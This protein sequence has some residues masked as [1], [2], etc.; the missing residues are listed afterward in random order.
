MSR[1][2]E[3]R[4]QTRH[5]FG[6]RSWLRSR[7]LPRVFSFD[8]KAQRQTQCVSQRLHVPSSFLHYHLS[9]SEE[10]MSTKCGHLFK[11]FLCQL[12]PQL[13]CE[14]VNDRLYIGVHMRVFMS[15]ETLY[16][17]KNN[18]IVNLALFQAILSVRVCGCGCGCVR[19]HC[20][21]R[22]S[23]TRLSPG[24]RQKGFECQVMNLF[25]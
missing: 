3:F 15:L 5:A 17:F 2:D 7:A 4:F 9:T 22:V 11:E 6:G 8:D 16:C 21:H 24:H 20:T 1:H 23:L 13:F 19:P 18:M 12:S 10:Q 14:A 25:F